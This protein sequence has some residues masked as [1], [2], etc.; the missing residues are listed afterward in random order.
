M[1]IYTH[2]ILWHVF[3]YFNHHEPLTWGDRV[4]TYCHIVAIKYNFVGKNNV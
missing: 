2:N 1:Y 3:S 4:L